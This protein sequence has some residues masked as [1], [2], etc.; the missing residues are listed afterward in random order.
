MFFNVFIKVKKLVFFY[1]HINVFNIYVFQVSLTSDISMGCHSC[2]N[3]VQLE[4]IDG[5]RRRTTAI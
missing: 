4:H 2:S 1:L 5:L 3:L